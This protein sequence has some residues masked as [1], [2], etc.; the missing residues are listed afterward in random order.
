MLTNKNAQLR[1]QILD[2]CFSDFKHKYTIN[3]LM[4]KVNDAL[5]DLTGTDISVRQI[6]AD[7]KYMR[8]RI[9]YDVPIKA[10]P[11]AVGKKSYYR[12]E[13]PNFT[14]YNNEL[15]IEEVDNQ[16]STIQMLGRYRGSPAT[17]WLEEV[18]SNL[19]Y[20]F[21]IKANAENLI[22]FEQND[23]LQG[24][25]HLS[26]IIDAT[27]NHQPLKLQYCTFKGHEFETICPP[28]YVKQYNNRWFLLGRNE[29]YGTIGNYAL[30]R[31]VSFR[32]VDIPFCKNTQI[33]FDT[34]FNDVIGVTVPK[35]DIETIVLRFSENRF[36]YVV[37]KPLH[38]SQVVN[39]EQRTITIQV[40]PN[41]ELNQLIFSF[42]PDV[43]VL[44][45]QSL[46]DFE[47]ANQQRTSV[48][49]VG[50]VIVRDGEIVDSY[51]SLIK[52]EPEYYS[53]WNTRVHRLTMEDTMNARV[54]P[55]VWAEIQPKIEGLPLVA[56]NSPFDEGCLK[57]VFQMYQMDYPDYE[58]HCTCRASRRKLGSLLPNHQLQTVAAYC[59]YD[60][61]QHHNALADAE[62]CAWIA[63]KL[64]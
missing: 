24:L 53:Y 12:Y 27:V 49:S 29:K 36:P 61:T 30:D 5:Y 38:H 43:E 9:T 64:L 28:Y 35:A 19:E 31:I 13:D 26:G 34:Y 10:Y 44:S 23:K 40:K 42:I 3:G 11:M 18:I 41:N 2:R 15:F 50:I 51:Y 54:F 60:L 22:S 16:R 55:E 7:I 56:H 59:G 63:R 52:P 17:A 62:A 21:G 4:D 33:N 32:N 47:T 46:R 14:I 37:S 8:D 48:C 45:P 57:S 20:C 6:R 25:E 1:Y 58:F 39:K